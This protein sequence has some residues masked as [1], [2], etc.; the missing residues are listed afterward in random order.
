MHILSLGLSGVLSAIPNQ[1]T[2]NS[3]G[4]LLSQFEDVLGTSLDLK[5]SANSNENAQKAEQKVLTELSRLQQILGTYG[6]NNEFAQWKKTYQQ[7]VEVSKEL[8]EIAQDFDFWKEQSQGAINPASEEFTQLW[9]KASETGIAPSEA[10]LKELIEK[11]Q[12]NH[13]EIDGSS[14]TKTSEADLKLHT[15]TK[16]Y[17]A[18]KVANLALDSEGVEGIVV[19]IG[20][21]IVVKGDMNE[22]V[23]VADPQAAYENAAPVSMVEINN[24]T[25]ASSGNYRRGVELNGEHLSHIFNPKTGKPADQVASATVI[26]EN[27]V[28]AGAL[29]TAFNILPLNE[30]IALANKFQKADYLIIDPSGNQYQSETWPALAKEEQSSISFVQLKE[31]EWNPKMECSIDLEIANLGGYARR[32]YVAI[33]IED[34]KGNPIRRIALWYRKPRWLVD[35]RYWSSGSRNAD[36]NISSITG[37]TRGSGKY[38]VVWDGKDDAGQYVNQGNYTV[39]IEA[40][41]EHGSYQ[42]MK[43]SMKFDD[44]A[45]AASFAGN[46]EISA[47]KLNFKTK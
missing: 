24:K 1:A 34:E 35:L 27:A 17:I 4:I 22:K 11:V 15:F 32:P 16:L 21:D 46:E 7:K 8:M 12:E 5:I 45:K 33:W 30:S 18:E 6:E 14:L 43:Q 42:L 29:A 26:H 20:G 40:A 23:K 2:E 47:A 13:W 31:K 9:K 19:N 10:E 25:I 28:T 36:Y 44:K 3:K 37:A 38:A 39:I 41:R